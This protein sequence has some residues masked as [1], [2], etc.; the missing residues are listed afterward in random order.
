MQVEWHRD[1]EP[2]D[3]WTLEAWPSLGALLNLPCLRDSR[4]IRGCHHGGQ[5]RRHRRH[6]ERCGC[7]CEDGLSFCGRSMPTALS[8]RQGCARPHC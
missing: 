6:T 1:A 2:S 8:P 3:L 5:F 4:H 7:V